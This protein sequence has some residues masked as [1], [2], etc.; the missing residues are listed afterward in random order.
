MTIKSEIERP[1][2]GCGRPVGFQRKSVNGFNRWKSGCTRCRYI[3]RKNKKDY[4]EKC[5]GTEKL[6]VD[7]ID[8]NRSNNELSN[9]QTLCQDCHHNKSLENNDYRRKTK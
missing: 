2:C 9:L 1:L 7:H 3:A 5:G 4:C 8:G 6:H